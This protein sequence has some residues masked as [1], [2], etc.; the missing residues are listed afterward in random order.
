M[1][2]PC[3]DHGRKG[4]GLGY[5]TAWVLREGVRST[6]TLHRKVYWE[7]TGEW[8][9]CVRHTCDNARCINPAHLVGGTQADNVQDMHTRGRAAPIEQTRHVGEDN[10]RC[11]LSY[12]Q[13]AEIRARYEPRSRLNGIPALSRHYGVGTSQIHRIIKG[14]QRG[15]S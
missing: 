14:V 6:T 1:N 7:T 5:A 3:I 12:Q 11:V 13:V 8:P 10:G 4:F 2:S 9:E 15:S